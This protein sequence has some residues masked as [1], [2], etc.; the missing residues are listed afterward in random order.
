M[1]VIE[2]YIETVPERQQKFAAHCKS[3]EVP[4]GPRGSPSAGWWDV[5]TADVDQASLNT[6][7][8]LTPKHQAMLSLP[9]AEAYCPDESVRGPAQG[10]V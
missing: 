9:T 5:R 6:R 8:V 10:A 4:T 2:G 7:L 3:G 1:W